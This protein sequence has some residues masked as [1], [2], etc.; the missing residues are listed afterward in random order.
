M[1]TL[2][3]LPAALVAAVGIGAIDVAHADEV[4]DAPFGWTGPYA[5]I[6][7]G[8][9]RTQHHYRETD[10]LDSTYEASREDRERDLTKGLRVGYNEAFGNLVLG[11]EGDLDFADTSGQTTIVDGSYEWTSH[12]ASDLQASLRGRAG[13]AMDRTLFYVTAGVAMADI[14]Y[15]GVD[16]FNTVVWHEGK[17][18]AAATFGGGVEYVVTP[19]WTASAEYRYTEYPDWDGVWCGEPRWKERVE[20]RSDAL[21]IGLNY[22]F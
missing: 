9:L 2:F 15:Q 21:R 20:L 17:T 12:V 22:H 18:V 19:Q 13:Y 8:L 10:A 1:K 11:I 5:G 4:E 16:E 7:A 3:L 14:T 6:Q